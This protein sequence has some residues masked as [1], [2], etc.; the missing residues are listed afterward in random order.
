MF[1]TTVMMC[2]QMPGR[3]LV[4]IFAIIMN[5]ESGIGA[6][7]GSHPENLQTITVQVET[8]GGKPLPNVAV[9]GVDPSTNAV[10]KGAAV[11]GG[12]RRWHTDAGGRFQFPTDNTNLAVLV[13]TKNGF[14]LVQ[15]SDLTNSPKMVVEPWG[16]IEGVRLN[17][18]HPMIGKLMKWDFDWRCAGPKIDYRIRT[19][20]TTTTDS[21]GHFAFDYVPPVGIDVCEAEHR[22]PRLWDVLEFLAIKPGENKHLQIATAG[23]TIVGQ[24]R[25]SEELPQ[26]LNLNSCDVVL[27]PASAHYVILPSI[28]KKFDTTEKRTEWWENWYQSKAGH[29]MFVPLDRRGS[30][31][32]VQSNGFFSSET[33]LAPGRYWA[34]GGLWRNGKK[35]A[36]TDQYVE[37]PK[38]KTDGTNDA[39]DIGS[40]ILKP[41]LQVGDLAPDF[42]VTTLD[43]KPLKLSEFRGKYV[44]LD[45]WATWCGPCV[46]ETPYLQATYDAFAKDSRFVMISLSL[47]EKQEAL[48]K[49]VLEKDI[50]WLQVFLGD[51]DQNRVT[52]NFEIGAIP[53]IWLIGPDGTIISRNL[54]GPEIKKAVASALAAK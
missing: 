50:R 5:C 23:R 42:H 45:F 41:A 10:L 31:L 26:N 6:N 54:R 48:K 22:K 30:S 49:F 32:E 11:E 39:F 27:T 12:S 53:S 37:I 15:S 17:R 38:G 29:Q 9:I 35:V 19:A 24:I 16:S 46:A 33:M 4:A 43:G 52:K 20:N 51:W 18:N 13:A 2:F 34:N 36:N 1:V 3:F 28:P 7:F 21:Q 8:S 14:S 40:V 44:L 47:D 25:L